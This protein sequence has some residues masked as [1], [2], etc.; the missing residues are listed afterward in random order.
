[1]V[2]KGTFNYQEVI[3]YE[4]TFDNQLLNVPGIYIDHD[5]VKYVGWIKEDIMLGQGTIS[6]PEGTLHMVGL[7]LK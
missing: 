1:M 5:G 3:K 4:L 7:N 6:F 2:V